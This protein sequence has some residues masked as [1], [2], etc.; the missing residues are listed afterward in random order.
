VKL[1]I[2]MS[3]STADNNRLLFVVGWVLPE[4]S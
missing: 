2:A 1:L 4:P 3:E